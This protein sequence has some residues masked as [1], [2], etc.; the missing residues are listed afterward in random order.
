M[1]IL[2]SSRLTLAW[3]AWDRQDFFRP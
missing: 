1:S 3:S 2:I